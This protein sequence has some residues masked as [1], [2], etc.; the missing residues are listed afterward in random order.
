MEQ[1]ILHF[2][3][4]PEQEERKKSYN[5]DTIYGDAGDNQGFS[6]PGGIS[7]RFHFWLRGLEIKENIPNW[8]PMEENPPL[9]YPK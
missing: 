7:A 6:H 3:L 9:M 2:G 5:S 4:Q 1:K 8:T